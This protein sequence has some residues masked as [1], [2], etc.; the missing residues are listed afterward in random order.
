MKNDRRRI[1]TKLALSVT[2][3][4]S[5][6]FVFKSSSVVEPENVVRHGPRPAQRGEHERLAEFERIG[7]ALGL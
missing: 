7:L 1:K 6:S 2:L 4:L 5:N 3:S